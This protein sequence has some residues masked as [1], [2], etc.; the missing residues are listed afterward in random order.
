M[1]LSREDETKAWGHCLSCGRSVK[2]QSYC[3]SC[4]EDR[5]GYK[6]KECEEE[7]ILGDT[8]QF[9]RVDNIER[10]YPNC[11]LHLEGSEL[12]NYAL[13]LIECRG[14]MIGE[15]RELNSQIEALKGTI[16][17]LIN[18]SNRLIY[19]SQKGVR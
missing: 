14:K 19:E 7:F 8:S 2:D 17:E 9:E 11:A 18:H 3:D 1:N 15:N 4:S 5:G 13:D 6:C 10:D 16:K 12:M